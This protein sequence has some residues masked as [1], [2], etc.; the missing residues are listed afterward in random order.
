MPNT[1]QTKKPMK[2]DNHLKLGV[3]YLYK[4]SDINH[5]PIETAKR[6]NP[7]P[8]PNPSVHPVSYTHLTLPTILLV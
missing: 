4:H 1:A 8:V 2:P 7:N 5:K 6:L 3:Q